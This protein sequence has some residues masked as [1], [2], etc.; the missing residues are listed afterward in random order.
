MRFC[1][2]FI[3][4]SLILCSCKKNKVDN[5]PLQKTFIGNLPIVSSNSPASVISGQDIISNVRCELSSISGGVLFQGFVIK[6]V[7]ALHFAISAKAFY[8][9]WNMYITMPA[10]WRL[11]TTATIKTTTPGR[12]ILNFYNSTLLVK[13]DTVQVN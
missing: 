13:S 9:D 2:S 11:D 3:I 8:K 1:T 4:F 7:P 6:E 12:Y 10:V 5:E